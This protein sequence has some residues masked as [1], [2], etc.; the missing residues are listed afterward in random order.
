MGLSF[1]CVTNLLCYDTYV[2][3]APGSAR[4][5]HMREAIA[6]RKK[7]TADDLR[8]MAETAREPEREGKLLFLADRWEDE[9]SW[10]ETADCSKDR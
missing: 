9:A 10:T 6:L 5:E 7:F 3:V 2:A 8:R 1:N 4:G